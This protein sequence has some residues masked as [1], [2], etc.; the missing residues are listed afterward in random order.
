MNH[1]NKLN[2]AACRWWFTMI[3]SLGWLA[4]SAAGAL[5]ISVPI[6]NASFESPQVDTF[7][8]AIDNWV[9][10][11]PEQSGVQVPQDYYYISG[12]DGRQVGWIWAGTLSQVLTTTIQ[13]NAVYTLTALVGN[14]CTDTTVMYA[15]QLVDSDNNIVLNEATGIANVGSLIKVATPP[16][17]TNSHP[18]Y[19]GHT[20]KIMLS[21]TGREANFDRVT[22]DYSLVSQSGALLLLL[23]D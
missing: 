9:T 20:L 2:R 10:T 8:Y 14:R 12:V 17:V 3:F 22:L 13:P 5:A 19:I 4:G 1:G 7:I 23:D 18:E 11:N 16:Y 15:V 6:L 21:S